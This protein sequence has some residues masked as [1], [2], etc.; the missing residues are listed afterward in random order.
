MITN[1]PTRSRLES[2]SPTG[3]HYDKATEA[4]YMIQGIL[5][6]LRGAVDPDY[7]SLE[8]FAGHV[9]SAADAALFLTGA[10]LEHLDSLHAQLLSSNNEA[11]HEG[12]S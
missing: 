8:V 12:I 2:D 7:N 1:T 9:A 5:G 10:A 6:V 11:P 4:I 3:S